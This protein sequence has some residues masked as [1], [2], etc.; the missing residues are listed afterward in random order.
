MTPTCLG[1]VGAAR[2]M[3]AAYRTAV[4]V[5]CWSLPGK[6]G[7]LAVRPRKNSKHRWILN[8]DLIHRDAARLILRGL[9][10]EGVAQEFVEWAEDRLPDGEEGDE[11]DEVLQDEMFDKM[12]E[13]GMIP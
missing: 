7:W 2:A 5:M 13:L 11:R 9:L 1:S 3:R 12:H 8:G 4:H 6:G 10:A